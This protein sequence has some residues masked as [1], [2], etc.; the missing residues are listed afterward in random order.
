VHWWG[1]GGVVCGGLWGWGG[2]GGIQ[3]DKL[4]IIATEGSFVSQCRRS[5]SIAVVS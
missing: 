1:G 2:G 3:M 5:L 4:N